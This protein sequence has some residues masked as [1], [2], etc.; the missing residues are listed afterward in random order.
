MMDK[1]R[2]VLGKR[3]AEEW[4]PWKGSLFWVCLDIVM[5]GCEWD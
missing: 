3:V 5:V 2:W 1:A 4:I